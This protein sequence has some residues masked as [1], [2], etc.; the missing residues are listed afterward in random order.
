MV[1][2]LT[3]GLEN[4]SKEYDGKTVKHMI[5]ELKHKGWTFTYIGADHNVEQIATSISIA[6]TLTFTKS[7]RDISSMFNKEKFSRIRHYSFLSDESKVDKENYYNK[8]DSKGQ[9]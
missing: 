2:V 3:D 8:D 7:T 9:V 4:D 6:N 1:T 5:E